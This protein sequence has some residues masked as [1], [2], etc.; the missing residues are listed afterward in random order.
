MQLV[1][2][3]TIPKSK[4]GVTCLAC[5][6]HFSSGRVDE[7][8]IFV[9]NG[10]KIS[11]QDTWNS[12]NTH[13]EDD[14]TLKRSRKPKSESYSDKVKRESNKR[15]PNSQES[16][17]HSYDSSGDILQE[18]LNSYVNSISNISCVTLD[19]S[20][21]KD[22]YDHSFEEIRN[23]IVD[24]LQE[25]SGLFVNNH[26]K[27]QKRKQKEPQQLRYDINLLIDHK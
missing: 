9:C 19:S 20:D 6:K 14:N 26:S 1:S 10:C 23:S 22:N 3:S 27:S 13:R 2:D 17:S 25:Y 11:E 16:L 12:L 8:G 4:R 21:S 18:C 24:R 15:P 7:S 5:D